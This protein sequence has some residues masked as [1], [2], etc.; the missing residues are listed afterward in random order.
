MTKEQNIERRS[1]R[2]NK[3]Q[4]FDMYRDIEYKEIHRNNTPK[5]VD[6]YQEQQ[7]WIA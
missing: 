6:N 3:K 1:N 5:Q 7:Q 2:K 4:S